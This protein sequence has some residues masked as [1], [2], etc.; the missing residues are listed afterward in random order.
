MSKLISAS[1]DADAPDNE[2]SR[3]SRLAERCWAPLAIVYDPLRA[4]SIDS[5]D[6]IPHDRAIIRAQNADFRPNQR[7]PGRPECTIFVGRLAQT[8]SAETLRKEFRRYGRV[9]GATVVEDI[10]TGRSRGYGFVEYATESEASIAYKSAH[11]SWLDGSR[12]FV[13]ME[14]GR[15][16]P[17]WV[18]RRLGGGFNGKKES[19]QLRFGCRERPFKKPIKL[20]SEAEIERFYMR[21]IRKNVDEPLEQSRTVQ[22]NVESSDRKLTR[23]R[24]RS[25]SPAR[26]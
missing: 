6:T 18:P 22:K 23:R 3:L 25:R 14:C 9:V 13:D 24:S 2:S 7:I 8:T 19:G 1:S 10:I 16:L 15:V 12:I 11:K 17:G 26:D 21:S 20:L 5:T 4:G